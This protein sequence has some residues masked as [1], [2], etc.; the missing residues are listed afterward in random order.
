[1]ALSRRTDQLVIDAV[2]A[3]TYSTTPGSDE[4]I[5][6]DIVTG[7]TNLTVDKLR[8]AAMD[9]LTDRNVDD[10]DRT[11]ILTA[12]GVK[13]LLADP[14]VTSADFVTL[15]A[16]VNGTLNQATFMGFNFCIIGQRTEGG[17]P[18]VGNVHTA[19]VY[20]KKSVGMAIGIDEMTEVN[21]IPEATSW[22]SNGLLKAG[23]VIRE[24]AGIVRIGY[25]ITA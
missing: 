8:E 19:F 25:D 7:G 17:L 11:I 20:Q 2:V 9:G 14:E 10:S 1:M 12:A 21:Y 4:N 5:G 16:L 6:Y 3:G 22:L 15:K 23:S 24:N 18:R 13:S